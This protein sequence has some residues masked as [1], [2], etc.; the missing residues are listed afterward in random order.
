MLWE[1]L[2]TIGHK[3]AYLHVRGSGDFHK[4]LQ[5]N[6]FDRFLRADYVVEDIERVKVKTARKRYSLGRDLGGEP[7]GL[8]STKVRIQIRDRQGE[9]I[10]S[11][12]APVEIRRNSRPTQENDGFELRGNFD[13]LP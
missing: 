6:K 12:W 8:D 7:W 2:E 3:V 11:G 4:I 10:D 13:I 5:P 9:K 1:L